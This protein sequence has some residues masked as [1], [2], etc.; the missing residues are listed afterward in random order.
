[1]GYT[2]SS[3]QATTI[4]QTLFQIRNFVKA[5]GLSKQTSASSDSSSMAKK[6]QYGSMRRNGHLSNKSSISGS[7]ALPKV[8]GEYLLPN[9]NW[10][11]KNCDTR[12]R[13]S[14]RDAAYL[15]HATGLSK[16]GHKWYTSTKMAN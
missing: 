5:R 6:K 4:L 3:H 15:A 8:S 13:H 12:S 14:E 16:N 2:T 10:S 11:F 7:E 1:M 9:L